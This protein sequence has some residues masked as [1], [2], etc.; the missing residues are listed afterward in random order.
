MHKK[1]VLSNW[2]PKVFLNKLVRISLMVSVVALAGATTI[3]AQDRDQITAAAVAG[4]HLKFT[5]VSPAAVKKGAAQTLPG[6]SGIDS[7]PNFSG[8][9]STPG[10]DPNGNPQSTWFFDTLGNPPS[11]AGTTTLG[12]PIVPVSIDLRNAD[13]SPRYVRVVNGKAMT[14]GN[15]SQAGCQRLFFDPTPFIEPI[16]ESPVFS[17]FNYTSS[18]VPTQFADSVQRAEYQGAKAKWHTLLAPSVKTTQTMVINQDPTCGTATGNGGTCNYQ[19]A[20]NA[21]GSCCFFVLLNV[22]T[23]QNELFPSTSTF[24]PDSSTPVGAAEA[25]GDITTKDVSTFFFPPAYLFIP[26]SKGNACCIGGFHMFDFESGDA[27]NGNLPRFFVL[28]YSTWDQPIFVDPTTLDV[29]GLSHEISETYN[30]PFVAFDGVHD[31][32][33]WWQAPN[34][35]CQDNL[36]VGDVI[37]GIPH[38]AFPITMPNGFTYHPQN[39]ALLQWFEFQS[40][41]TALFG[42]YSYPDVATLT[43]LSAPQKA[44]CAP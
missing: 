9:Y 7:V 10:F 31:I 20:L 17:N 27:K 23:F 38:Q 44:N 33:P 12:G 5:R 29:T 3:R 34:G 36:E 18:A 14:C 24:P 39:E 6:I 15:A 4:K 2:V 32:T 42:A 19:Y 40:P 30:D 26:T 43:A 28:N 13:G 41:S 35:N 1:K 8:T 21:D 37:E 25:S 11:T 22:N 16:L